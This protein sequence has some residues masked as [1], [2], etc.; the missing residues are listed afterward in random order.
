M[1]VNVKALKK[2]RS[3]A[4]TSL[5]S[6]KLKGPFEREEYMRRAGALYGASHKQ[7]KRAIRVVCKQLDWKP[8]KWAT[9]LRGFTGRVGLFPV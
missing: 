5:E 4:R 7:V 9:W 6:G 2:L 1:S 8:P 3:A